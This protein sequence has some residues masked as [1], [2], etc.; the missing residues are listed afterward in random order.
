MSGRDT[1]LGA[2]R[3]ATQRIPPPEEGVPQGYRSGLDLAP[4]ELL[5]VYP[6]FVMR[7]DGARRS[8]R[9]IPAADRM[10]F[11]AGLA[12]QL[13]ALPDGTAVDLRVLPRAAI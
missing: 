3:Q 5:S 8:Y 6:P 4:G 7:A 2:V 12:A 9:A 13:R 1:I 11:L 10:E